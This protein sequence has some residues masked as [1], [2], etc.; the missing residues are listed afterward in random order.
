[1]R[2]FLSKIAS[3]SYKQTN[4]Q[5]QVEPR[6]LEDVIPKFPLDSL[7]EFDLLE[8]KIMDKEAENELV[9]IFI[10]SSF[11]QFMQKIF[12]V[13]INAIIRTI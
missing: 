1:M 5:P 3:S 13:Y 8:E 9:I 4:H 6:K 2:K 10:F 7:E 12:S 11:Q